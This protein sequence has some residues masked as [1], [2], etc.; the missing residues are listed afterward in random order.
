M[1]SRSKTNS[2]ILTFGVQTLPDFIRVCYQKIKVRPY[3]PNPLRCFK[4]QKFGHHQSMCRV[5]PICAKCSLPSHGESPCTG[6]V[7]CSNCLGD[8]PSYSPVC[9]K[10]REEKEVCRIKVTNNVTYPE[11][12][13][14]LIQPLTSTIIDICCSSN[15]T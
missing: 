14:L 5:D 13:K 11:A 1:E 3:I 15:C 9:P 8:H 12:R 7:K 4:C 2:I 6:A 10:W